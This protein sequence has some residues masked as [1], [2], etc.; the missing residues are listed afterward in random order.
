MPLDHWEADLVVGAAQFVTA[1]ALRL[2]MAGILADK[3]ELLNG[4]QG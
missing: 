1:Y 4:T 3:P 2:R